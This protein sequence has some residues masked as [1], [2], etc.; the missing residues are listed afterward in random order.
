[1]HR[2]QGLKIIVHEGLIATHVSSYSQIVER[3]EDAVGPYKTEP[4]VDPSQ[5]LIHHAACHLGEPEVG[6][7]EDSEDSRDCHYQMEVSNYEIGR[8]QH[9]VDRRLGQE[10]AAH[11][12]ADEHRNEAQRKERGRVDSQFRAVQTA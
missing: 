2:D 9:D 6:S 10:K 7:S 8:M 4:E 3:H 12:A 11:T 1:M 5:C